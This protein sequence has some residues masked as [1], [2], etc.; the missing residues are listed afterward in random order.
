MPPSLTACL[1]TLVPEVDVQKILNS[2]GLD[3]FDLDAIVATFEG[4]SHGRFSGAKA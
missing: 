3:D 2:L 4:Q 1:R